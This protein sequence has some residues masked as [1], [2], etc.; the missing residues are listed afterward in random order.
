[1]GSLFWM[2]PPIGGE[3][4]SPPLCIEPPTVTVQAIHPV[5][6]LPKFPRRFVVSPFYALAPSLPRTHILH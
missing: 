2:L 3:S 5:T 4:A 1:M 6:L